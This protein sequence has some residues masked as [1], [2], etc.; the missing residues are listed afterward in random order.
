M[1]NDADALNRIA[2]WLIL[3]GSIAAIVGLLAQRRA[4]ALE[5]ARAVA[6]AA[7]IADLGSANI[8]LSA[9]LSASKKQVAALEVQT[10][11]L[12]RKALPRSITSQQRAAMVAELRKAGPQRVAVACRM[13]DL[14]ACAYAKRRRTVRGSD[15]DDGFG[16]SFLAQFV[17]DERSNF[18]ISLSDE[19][20]HGDVG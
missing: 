1:W 13:F 5:D 6:S 4:K 9:D 16:Q 12:K 20:E 17:F 8:H 14:E 10:A 15:H 2:F 3:L 7:K 19:R 18:A 11:D